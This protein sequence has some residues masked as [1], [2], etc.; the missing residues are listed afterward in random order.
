MMT[1]TRDLD[2]KNLTSLGNAALMEPCGF[3]SAPFE[4]KVE[5]REGVRVILLVNISQ[6][7]V[8]RSQGITTGFEPA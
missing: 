2:M 4:T 6:G 7:L 3:G 8:N 5:L 1:Y